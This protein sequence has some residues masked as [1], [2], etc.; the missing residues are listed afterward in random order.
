MCPTFWSKMNSK[1]D[2]RGGGKAGELV[3]FACY[4]ENSPKMSPFL[5]PPFQ[6]IL[7]PRLDSTQRINLYA[8]N[9]NQSVKQEES[10]NT[11]YSLSV[12]S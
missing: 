10:T 7:E 3:F 11:L 5:P 12:E 1:A 2:T 4:N 8:P 9:E 6:G